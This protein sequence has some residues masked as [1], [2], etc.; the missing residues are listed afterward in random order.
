MV[1]RVSRRSDTSRQGVKW[2][3]SASFLLTLTAAQHLRDNR[4]QGFGSIT[5]Q[6]LRDFAIAPGQMG[7]S[8][9]FI[10]ERILPEKI[11]AKLSLL[12]DALR[13]H[14]RLPGASERK[15]FLYLV[16]QWSGKKEPRPDDFLRTIALR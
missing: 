2:L 9:R 14:V 12:I 3:R 13:T 4:V 7:P 6:Q 15:H 8:L 11:D 10:L 1:G 16:R 5:E